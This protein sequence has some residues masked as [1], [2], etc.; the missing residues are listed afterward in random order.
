MKKCNTSSVQDM[1]PSYLSASILS[2]GSVV[3]VVVD[4]VSQVDT[5]CC[6]RCMEVCVS[7]LISDA[8]C[9]AVSFLV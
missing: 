4:V 7:L 2:G 9:F 8:A 5:L 6:S 1:T 3:I